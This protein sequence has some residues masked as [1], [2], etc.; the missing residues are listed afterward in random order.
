[1]CFVPHTLN[2]ISKRPNG[3]SLIIADV[4]AGQSRITNATNE[5]ACTGPVSGTE[6][7]ILALTPQEELILQ[8][9]SQLQPV[10][11]QPASCDHS[12]SSSSS[13]STTK[14][15]K[16]FSGVVKPQIKFSPNVERLP[17]DG[18]IAAAS[19][20]TVPVSADASTTTGAF[21]KYDHKRKE[22]QRKPKR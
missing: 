7:P 21:R 3:L 13:C 19:T 5:P 14:S 9:P 16:S 10:H 12:P 6:Q 4:S 8:S 17:E 22:R 11:G 18:S 15:A 2:Y 1:M 20:N